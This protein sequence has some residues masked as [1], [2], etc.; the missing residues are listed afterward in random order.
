MA[1][2][3]GGSVKSI[4]AK[5]GKKIERF[6]PTKSA[7]NPTQIPDFPLTWGVMLKSAKN[8]QKPSG[9]RNRFDLYPWKV[10]AL[11]KAELRDPA[12]YHYDI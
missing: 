8:A 4:R 1:L 7:V 6:F 5:M 11:V 12:F 3:N 9:P 10:R 2:F